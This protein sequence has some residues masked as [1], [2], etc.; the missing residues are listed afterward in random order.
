M[1]VTGRI[2]GVPSEVWNEE[3][4]APLFALEVE[5]LL[6]YYIAIEKVLLLEYRRM[7]LV[8][9]DGAAIIANRLDAVTPDLLRADRAENMSDISFA[10]ERFVAAGP[11]PPFAAWH[12]DRS[13]NDLQACAQLMSAR[14]QVLAVADDLLVFGQAVMALAERSADI[15]MPGYTHA[16]AAQIITPGFYFAALSA[17]TLTSAQRLARTYDEIDASPLGAGTMAGQ[18]L[19]WDRERMAGLLGFSRAQSHA[20]VAVAS[21][22]WA[23][24]ISS[25]LSNFAVTLSRFVTDLMAWGG[26]E[27]GFIDLPDNLSGIS[28][29][30]PQK[31]NFPV[32]ERI[33]GRCSHVTGS[34]F[35]L[36]QTQRNTSYTNTVEVSKEAGAHLRTQ[37]STLGSTLR[38]M[39]AVVTNMGFRTDRM[40][41]A[42][43]G[44]YLGG[45]TLAN[46][47]ALRCGIPWRTAQVIVGRY[48][49]AALDKGLTPSEPD[50]TL[51]S[52][53]AGEY[54][55]EV[56]EPATLL[57]AT[58]GVDHGL[59]AKRSS[60]STNPDSVRVMLAMQA[61]ENARLAELWG[62]RRSAAATAADRVDAL[63]LA[64]D[65]TRI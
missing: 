30:M 35:E 39:H 55:H 44:E 37:L 12:V 7:G 9:R 5:F 36:A 18:E 23:L 41:Q 6:P 63:L 48:V 62:A 31:C 3:V 52:V 59:Q 22:G 49:K 20:L 26:S 42:C 53:L 28:A 50:G 25:D 11:T 13:R 51:L 32:I 4:L 45:F 15:P 65:G 16:Q 14:E 24:A 60:G 10:L 2:D 40:R 27:Y 43:E 38:L 17:E 34:A 8:D 56:T 21:R 33:R 61:N 58:L 46:Q 19:A 57:A 29:A 47:L 1:T 54:G 64:D